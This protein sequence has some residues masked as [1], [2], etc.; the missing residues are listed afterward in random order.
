MENQNASRPKSGSNRRRAPKR[1]RKHRNP[2]YIPQYEGPTVEGGGILEIGNEGFGFLRQAKN[3]FLPGEDDIYV[4]PG[5]INQFKLREGSEVVGQ[6][7]QPRRPGQKP[8][9]VS[10]E[11]VDGLSPEERMERPH[12]KELTSIDPEP[13]FVLE[14]GEGD[15]SLRIMDLL[16][17]IGKGQR[18]LLVAPPRTGKT[19]LLQK[20]ASAIE[21]HYP[22]VELMV[23]LIDERPEEATGWRRS[24]GEKGLVLCSTLDEMARNHVALSEIVL[25][26]AHRLVECGRDVVIVLDSITRLARAYNAE[27]K[28][29]GRILT[30]GIDSRTMEKPKKFFGSARNVEEGGSLTILATALI[31]TGSRMDQV[32]FEEFKGTGNMEL[33]FSRTLADRR[34]FPAMD[35]ELSGTRKEEKLLPAEALN[36]IYTLRRVLAKLRPHEAMPLL[37]DRLKK[38]KSNAEFLAAFKAT[39][40]D[41]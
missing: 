3:N 10:L 29:S 12:F 19:V 13:M 18:G 23:L 41:I 37:I 8:L 21:Q 33:V 20:V 40:E 5:L 17:P 22:E 36:R 28:N 31:E 16:T 4:P 27:I 14:P 30:G 34:I 11:T 9:L 6:V 38:T 2:N 15:I 7:G 35:I 39:E 32:I 26:R 25:K 24:L 1:R